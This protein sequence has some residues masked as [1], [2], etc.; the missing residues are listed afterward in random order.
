MC[1]HSTS[2]LRRQD[3]DS[4]TKTTHLLKLAAY[5]LGTAA[6]SIAAHAGWMRGNNLIGSAAW[7]A[8]GMAA[9][10]I[11][12]LA[13][14]RIREA[15]A[16]NQGSAAASIAVAYGLAV[17]MA[18]ATALG[19]AAGGRVAAADGAEASSA[20]RKRAQVAYESATAELASLLATRSTAEVNAL[21]APLSAKIGAVNCAEWVANRAVR[22]A[23]SD[24]HPL[25]VELARSTRKAAL[26]DQQTAAAAAL[27]APPAPP[28]NSDAAAIAA[29]LEAVGVR[30]G[31]DT[32]A[33]LLVLLA[34]AL[35]D[36]AP[37]L[38]LG[39][40]AI[41]A[42]SPTALASSKQGKGGMLVE[43]PTPAPAPANPAANQSVTHGVK[44]YSSEG[45][46]AALKTRLLSDLAAGSRLTSHRRLAE[47]LG[48]S[49]GS[50]QRAIGELELAGAIRARSERTGTRLELA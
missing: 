16:R 28:A 5:A 14:I 17:M 21:I 41:A 43:S 33:K 32:V 31:A 36:I 50:V 3:G 26:L 39:S 2:D 1:V 49:V 25:S 8:V 18:I 27:A 15:L 4:H 42:A 6:L 10:T 45:V 20:E 30:V 40:L 47:Q 9:V 44:A 37:G 22:Q 35:L 13:P 46:V 48:A 12:L 7:A 24:R 29:Y 38:L 23:C 11:A 19:S 34:V